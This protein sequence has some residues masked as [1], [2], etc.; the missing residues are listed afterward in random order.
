MRSNPS[1]DSSVLEALLFGFLTIL[2]I[3]ESKRRLAEEQ[4]REI[5]E[6]Q[7]WAKLVFEKHAGGD[8]E[9]DRVKM[10]AASVL[11]RISEVAEKYQALLL[12]SLM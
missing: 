3:N 4:P 10:L 6:T 11:M 8:E 5:L 9:S 7:G 12:G 1:N 2:E